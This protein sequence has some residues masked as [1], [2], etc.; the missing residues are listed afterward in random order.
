MVETNQCV[1]DGLRMLEAN[2]IKPK[3]DRSTLQRPEFVMIDE[4]NNFTSTRKEHYLQITRRNTRIQQLK[5]DLDLSTLPNLIDNMRHDKTKLWEFG[6]GFL[7]LATKWWISIRNG[8]QSVLIRG[9]ENTNVGDSVLPKD[10]A[11]GMPDAL[12]LS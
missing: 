1:A 3:L 7:D 9:I 10:L 8:F 2:R 4:M 5:R 11:D 12:D 6:N